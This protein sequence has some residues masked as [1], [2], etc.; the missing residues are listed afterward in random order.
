M[1]LKKSINKNKSIKMLN[2]IPQTQW[3]YLAVRIWP[4]AIYGGRERDREKKGALAF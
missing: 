1:E 4:E 3:Q 2:N